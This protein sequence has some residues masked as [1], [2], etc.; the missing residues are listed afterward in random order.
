[1]TNEEILKAAQEDN[2]TN[3]SVGE[4]EKN[5]TR[6]GLI[7]ATCAGIVVYLVMVVFEL[8]IAHKYDFGK[9]AI[10]FLIVAVMDLYEGKK[11]K[12]KKKTIAGIVSVIVSV[13]CLLLYVGAMLR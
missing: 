6:T 1:M 8:C 4:F 13:I 2:Q 3:Q 10:F 9:P 11:L 12:I 5:T 7:Y